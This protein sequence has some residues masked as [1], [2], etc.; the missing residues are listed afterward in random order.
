MS[1]SVYQLILL[2]SS[3]GVKR[4]R[5][6]DTDL[7]DLQPLKEK[8]LCLIAMNYLD[9]TPPQSSFKQLIFALLKQ[10]NTNIQGISHCFLLPSWQI[11]RLH[12]QYKL[13]GST[14]ILIH[15][16]ETEMIASV[17]VLSVYA[18]TMARPWPRLLPTFK[19][20]LLSTCWFFFFF[21]A[22]Q[23]SILWCFKVIILKNLTERAF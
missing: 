4:K 19:A 23:I 1:L 14:V 15:E 10:L 2:S 3:S 17:R 6:S 11:C 20:W 8:V 13:S 7:E 5:Q 16:I 21:N 22:E 12:Y 18:Q 9:T